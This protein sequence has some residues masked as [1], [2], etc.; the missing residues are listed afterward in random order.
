MVTSVGNGWAPRPPVICHM[1]ELMNHM[2]NDSSKQML[3]SHVGGTFWDQDRKVRDWEGFCLHRGRLQASL[4]APEI[5]S[6]LPRSERIEMSHPEPTQD[7]LNGKQPALILRGY[8]TRD[9]W[10][11]V[12]LSVGRRCRYEN[13]KFA[14][15]RYWTRRKLNK[16]LPETVGIRCK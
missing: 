8:A 10:Y 7:G 15:G 14:G 13:N 4:S 9:H 3:K 11:M 5:S 12:K 6:L 2:V 1:R 16:N